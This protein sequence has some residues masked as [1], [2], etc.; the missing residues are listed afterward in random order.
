[1]AN[2]TTLSSNSFEWSFTDASLAVIIVKTGFIVFL[3]VLPALKGLVTSY[4]KY[5]NF[6]NVKH[7]RQI[8]AIHYIYFLVLILNIVY[9]L[10]INLE[11]FLS[12]MLF[13][14]NFGLAIQLKIL[15][16]RIMKQ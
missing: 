9:Q 11:P 13:F 4:R 12:L 5:R 2:G 7:Y 8:M 1:M 14:T 10:I 16:E 15:A 3:I 6:K